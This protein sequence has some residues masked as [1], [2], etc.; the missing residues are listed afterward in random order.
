[1]KVARALSLILPV[2]LLPALSACGG[3]KSAQP[4]S[5][6]ASN[7]VKPRPGAPRE[8]LARAIDALFTDPAVGET[9]AVLVLYNGR[10][11]AE[12]YAPGYTAQTRHIGWS[13]S[14]T[15]T[16]IVI[17]MLVADGRLKLDESVPV[18]IWQRPGDPRGEIT[19][20]QL[21]Q[22][23]SGLQHLETAENPSDADTPRMLFLDGR[24]NMAAYAEAQPLSH[25]PGREW[26]YSTA[27]SVIL[28]D[29][30]TR[31]LTDSQD[32]AARRQAMN[33]YLH[34]RL[35][36]PLGLTSM[37]AEYDAAGTMLG[38]SMI[39]ATARDWARVGE[40]LRA[41]GVVRGVPLM[42]S[43]WV[44]WMTSPSPANR[45]YG[46]QIWLNR[47]DRRAP[48]ELFPERG[49]ADAYALIGH[50]GQYVIV[51]PSLNLTLVRLGHTPDNQRAALRARLGDIVELYS[52]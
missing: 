39:H 15:V 45:A 37:V 49:P 23:R 31:T 43:D 16:G 8:T 4:L 18:P 46:A 26:R 11:V 52:Q 9:R 13:M 17:G 25:E 33:D 48:D 47:H 38:G 40:F 30:A 20:R 7:A 6:E 35:Y 22:M 12:R 19:L 21:L 3:G 14:K 27:T 24:D 44:G 36:V 51:A 28:A 2:L 41:N 42:P 5:A 10:I 29:V 50:L 32:P 1:M 34:S